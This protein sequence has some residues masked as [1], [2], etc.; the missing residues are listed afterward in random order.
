MHWNGSAATSCQDWMVYPMKCTLVCR[1]CLCLFWRICST[2]G[3]LTEP[4]LVVLLRSWSHY[5]R[6]LAGMS[7]VQDK[8]EAQVGAWLRR[9]LSLKGRAEV[10]AVHISS[11]I[12]N[13][14][15]VPSLPK[16]PRQALKRSLFKLL[17]GGRKPMVRWQ[18]C[19]Q[20]QRNGGLGMSDREKDWFAE[21]L[22]Y[23]GRS[24]SKDP[25]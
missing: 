19:C 4:S 5:W 17:L 23:L 15:S 11:L 8:V 14:L 9:G 22:A 2:I 16:D 12:L 24:W 3:S 6:K 20:R 18:V 21:R 7:E 13:H 10:C 1:T 25:V